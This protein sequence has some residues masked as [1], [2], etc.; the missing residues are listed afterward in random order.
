MLFLFLPSNLFEIYDKTLQSNKKEKGERK[1]P[2]IISQE[3]R[4][5]YKIPSDYA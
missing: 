4:G 1:G 2:D 3:H 5:C